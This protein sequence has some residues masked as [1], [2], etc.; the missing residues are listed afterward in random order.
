MGKEILKA[1][2]ALNVAQTQGFEFLKNQI[3]KYIKMAAERGETS[4]YWDFKYVTNDDLVSRIMDFFVDLGYSVII[5]DCATV[6]KF[7]FDETKNEIDEKNESLY[8]YIRSNI[9]TEGFKNVVNRISN[10][11]LS[12]AENGL[13]RTH[14]NIKDI[15]PEILKRV[16]KPYKET[17]FQLEES[18]DTLTIS[19][20][21]PLEKIVEESKKKKAN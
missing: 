3:A 13:I 16:L 12:A 5:T 10:E 7:S 21:K 4:T 20:A 9:K 18:E 6:I 14:I 8:E 1:S 15:S 11:I 19:W 17:G 2:E